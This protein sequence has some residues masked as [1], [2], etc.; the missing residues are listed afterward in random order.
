M[1]PNEDIVFTL[2]KL[3]TIVDNDNFGQKQ[4]IKKQEDKAINDEIDLTRLKNEIDSGE[5]PK[6]IEF[7]FGGPN[8]NFFKCVQLWI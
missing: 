2:H 7:N 6:E 3:P 8:Q 4:E 1:V 5:I